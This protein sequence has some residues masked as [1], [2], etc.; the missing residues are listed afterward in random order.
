MDAP[1]NGGYYVWFEPVVYHAFAGAE[2]GGQ[3]TWFDCYLGHDGRDKTYPAATTT[4]NLD[5]IRTICCFD[6][7]DVRPEYGNRKGGPLVV[8]DCCGLVYG[9]FGICHQMVNRLFYT[10]GEPVFFP[11]YWMVTFLIWGVYGKPVNLN[12]LPK[13]IKEAFKQVLTI[14]GGSG[15]T[16][17]FMQYLQAC[18]IKLSGSRSIPRNIYSKNKII[19]DFQKIEFAGKPYSQVDLLQVWLKHNK[20]HVKGLEKKIINIFNE[21]IAIKSDL[22]LQVLGDKIPPSAFI[23]EVN[24]AFKVFLKKLVSIMGPEK[25]KDALLFDATE[26]ISLIPTDGVKIMESYF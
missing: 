24:S 18:I 16:V 8:G 5:L 4:G 22:D 26:E 13:K 23:H 9:I 21:L 12:I 20:K 14:I 19:K 25:I 3:T 2:S 7:Q 1:I 17:D 10:T 15:H 11:P 6:P